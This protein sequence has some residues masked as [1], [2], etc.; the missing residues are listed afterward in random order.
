MAAIELRSILLLSALLL[1]GA[2][3][4][5]AGDFAHLG[6]RA[7]PQ[8]P[9]SIDKQVLL[10]NRDWSREDAGPEGRRGWPVLLASYGASVVADLVSTRQA[11]E[12]G[13]SEGNPLF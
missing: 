13:A 2:H 7:S 8:V 9:I 3:R 12:R 4:C 5:L 10:P 11:L 1:T 6:E